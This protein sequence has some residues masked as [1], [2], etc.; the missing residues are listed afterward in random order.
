MAYDI[1]V[2]QTILKV[3]LFSLV[4]SLIPSNFQTANANEILWNPSLP[5]DWD[6][7]A[8]LVPGA[9]LRSQGVKVYKSNPDEMI[10][11]IQ[12]A[13]S[14]EDRPFS[15]KGRNIAMWLYWPKDYCWTK[16][17]A[18]CEG[19]FTIRPPD[20]PASYPSVKSS[21]YVFV[22]RHNKAS[23]V[24]RKPTECKAPWWIDSTFNYR[25]TLNFAV[26]IT[27]LGLPKSFG[28]YAYSSIDIGQSNPA[29]Q[30]SPYNTISYPFHDLAA[31]AAA[32]NKEPT[33][34]TQSKKQICVLATTGKG[35]EGVDDFDEQCSESGIQWEFIYCDVHTK[36]D[37]EVFQNKKWKK[38]KT[39]KGGKGSCDDPT[40]SNTFTF[41]SP[42]L[43]KHRIK[44]YGN[45]KFTTSY[46]D[47]KIYRK[48]IA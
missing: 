36:A 15:G 14:F 9:E 8:D 11:Q 17:D 6:Q 39:I 10:F 29:T 1:G 28:T 5:G 41:K 40:L 23:N 7:P 48:D 30:F 4:V 21:E 16:E 47:L 26:S 43:G 42:L 2:L 13:Q 24:D 45:N 38:V 27:C 12:M 44:N 22:M 32:K 20:N 37:L 33:L 25:D 18:N 19:L 35:Y 3:G 34:S 46:I 31:S